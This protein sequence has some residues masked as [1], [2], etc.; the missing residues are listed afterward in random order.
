MNDGLDGAGTEAYARR[1]LGRHRRLRALAAVLWS[2][3][4]GAT[5]SMITLQL[6]PR[7]WALPPRT[8]DGAGWTFLA[9]WLLAFVPTALA[10]VLFM[11]HRE[12]D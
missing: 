12:P 10:A 8:L 5:L 2:S 6:L 4:L 7:D 3:F 11:P 9:L 1:G